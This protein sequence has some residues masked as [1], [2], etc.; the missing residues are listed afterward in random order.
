MANRDM[1]QAGI[2]TMKQ[3]K[4]RNTPLARQSRPHCAGSR[5][6]GCVVCCGGV[7]EEDTWSS[8]NAE[9]ASAFRPCVMTE[10]GPRSFHIYQSRDNPA[11]NNYLVSL[12]RLVE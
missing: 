4:D 1:A 11:V 3:K 8:F 10:D 7:A 2:R 9:V 6:D 5:K 12:S